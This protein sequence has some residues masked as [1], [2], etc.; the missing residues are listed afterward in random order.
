MPHLGVLCSIFEKLL[1]YL[2]TAPS[3]SS[4][5]KVC[6]KNKKSLNLGSKI[7]YLV[8]LGSIFEKLLS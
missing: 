6:Y 3:N 4:N 1:S 8:A 5:C 2:K 7:P